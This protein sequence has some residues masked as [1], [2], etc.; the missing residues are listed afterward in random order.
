M[1][2]GAASDVNPAGAYLQYNE[3]R[4]DLTKIDWKATELFNSTLFTTLAK[5]GCATCCVSRCLK[6]Y[7]SSFCNFVVDFSLNVVLLCTRIETGLRRHEMSHSVWTR[8]LHPTA[9]LPRV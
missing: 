6:L 9:G 4:R 7:L 5:L 8:S 1:P 2:R 3:V